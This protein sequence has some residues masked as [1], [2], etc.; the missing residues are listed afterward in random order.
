ME[1]V[2]RIETRLDDMILWTEEVIKRDASPIGPEEVGLTL[3]EGKAILQRLQNR[4]VNAQIDVVSAAARPCARCGKDK[5]IKDRRPRKLRTVFGVVPVSSYRYDAWVAPAG[6]DGDAESEAVRFE[7]AQESGPVPN[8]NRSY[9][10]RTR[11]RQENLGARSAVGRDADR[12]D[13]P[14][15]AWSRRTTPRSTS[16]AAIRAAAGRDSS[17]RGI[18]DPAASG[19]SRSSRA[20]DQTARARLECRLDPSRDAIVKAPDCGWCG[21]EA[22]GMDSDH[23]LSGYGISSRGLCLRERS[24]V[25]SNSR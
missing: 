15:G 5:A 25:L 4:I 9:P 14:I 23:F 10:R 21:S 6:S 3:M 8:R 16:G 1:F 20:R 2:I 17:R 19:P 18:G 22:K 12:Q 11:H 13:S 7:S 24:A